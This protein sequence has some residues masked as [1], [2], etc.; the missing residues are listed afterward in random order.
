MK[1]FFHSPA[2]A[3][4]VLTLSLTF[5][6]CGT[7]HISTD[8]EAR[9][10]DKARNLRGG[11]CFT[12]DTRILMADGSQKCI[13]DVHMGDEV[14]SY[15]LL[16]GHCEPATVQG[17]VEVSHENLVEYVFAT[18]SVKATTD[19]PFYLKD[20]GWASMAPAETHSYFNFRQREVAAIEPGDIF[21]LRDASGYLTEAVLEEVRPLNGQQATW[22][23]VK[24]SKNDA[25]FANG[26]LTGVE[27]IASPVV[28]VP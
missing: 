3:A 7:G 15:N 10:R 14:M 28:V 6:A 13:R 23:I 9:Q 27:E 25:Y 20:K 24:L 8:R 5:V 4:L 12:G 21:M 22:S 26:T 2:F 11:C 19:H 16:M 18:H 1:R 17:L